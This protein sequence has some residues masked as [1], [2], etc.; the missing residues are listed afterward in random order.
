MS[1]FSRGR[2]RIPPRV[3]G[4][5]RATVH[6]HDR[7]KRYTA[8]TISAEGK[9]IPAD[10]VLEH[11]PPADCVRITESAGNQSC[12]YTGSPNAGEDTH[13]NKAG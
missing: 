6:V 7:E 1:T 3:P 10:S 13:K 12:R 8:G 2:Y 4:P 9:P 11:D 5:G